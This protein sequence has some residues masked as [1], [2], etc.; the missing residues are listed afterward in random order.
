MLAL[1]NIHDKTNFVIYYTVS[2]MPCI[3]YTHMC[4]SVYEQLICTISLCTNMLTQ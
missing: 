1:Y 2:I 4:V 3:I